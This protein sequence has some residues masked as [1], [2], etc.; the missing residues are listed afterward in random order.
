[1]NLPQQPRRKFLQTGVAGLCAALFATFPKISLAKSYYNNDKGIIVHED[2]GIHILTGRRKVPITVKISK[3]KD[4]IDGISFCVE[5]QSPGRKMR[6]HKHLYNDE[7]IFIQ[8]GE[9]ILTLDEQSIQVKT[10]DVAF[11]PRGTWHGLDNT[12]KENLLM[13]FQYS[14]AGFEE[15]FIENGTLTGMPAKEKSGEEYAATEK[16]YGMI[17]KQP[18]ATQ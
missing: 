15:Y 13:I 4:G 14:P 10:G 16:K 2:E 6:I 7:I 12:G 5:D 8:K 11:V 1:M 17:Y 9:G 18:N 3:A